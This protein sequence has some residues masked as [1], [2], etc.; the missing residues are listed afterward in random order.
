MERYIDDEAEKL[1]EELCN[2]EV[3]RTG[4]PLE[5]DERRTSINGDVLFFHQKN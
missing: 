5:Y 1:I 2:K 3:K 4:L